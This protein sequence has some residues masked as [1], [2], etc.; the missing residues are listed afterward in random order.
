MGLAGLGK[1]E[2]AAIRRCHVDVD[3]SQIGIYRQKTRVAF[4][5][6]IYPQLRPLVEKLCEGKKPNDRLLKI[7]QARKALTH[8]CARLELPRYTQLSGPCIMHITR[9]LELGVDV[10]TVALW[11]G[12][13]DQGVLIL[14]TYSHVRPE[15]SNR[16]AALLT[17]ELPSNV[18]PMRDMEG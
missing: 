10:K 7:D 13:K 3:A 14:R 12:H 18:V 8:S 17:A 15:H 9:C 1:A 5:I 2:V 4:F 6:P 16:M 11:Q